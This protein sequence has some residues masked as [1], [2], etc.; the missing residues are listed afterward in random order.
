MPVEPMNTGF[1]GIS[2][3]SSQNLLLKSL[4]WSFCRMEVALKPDSHR[5]VGIKKAS[6]QNDLKTL[7]TIRIFIRDGVLLYKCMAYSRQ[8][9]EKNNLGA[10][11]NVEAKE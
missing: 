1:T 4:Y 6:K 2:K 9:H 7:I 5:L 8:F 11:L 3:Y 10:T